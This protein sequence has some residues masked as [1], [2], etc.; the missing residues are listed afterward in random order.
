M[1][2]NPQ[3]NGG[4]IERTDVSHLPFTAAMVLGISALVTFVC[5]LYSISS[6]QGWLFMGV[7]VVVA[8]TAVLLVMRVPW[9][10]WAALVAALAS[11]TVSA[12]WL[13]MYPWFSL[14]AIGLDLLA[15]YAIARTKLRLRAGKDP[16]RT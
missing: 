6:W 11:L 15:I 12:V 10:L 3:S 16:L 5:G 9:G 7:G 13:A 1:T 14:A 8:A 2:E 4:R